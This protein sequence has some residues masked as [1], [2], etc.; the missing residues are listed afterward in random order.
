MEQKELHKDG[1]LRRV[2]QF[3]A[4]IHFKLQSHEKMCA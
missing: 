2:R 3:L 4:T 1:E